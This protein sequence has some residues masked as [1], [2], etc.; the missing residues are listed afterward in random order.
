MGGPA[1]GELVSGE[2][3]TRADALGRVLPMLVPTGLAAL[4]AALALSLRRHWARPAVLLPVF[5]AAL[6]PALSGTG[7]MGDLVTGALMALPIVA[8]LVWYLY[9]VEGVKAYFAD[10]RDPGEPG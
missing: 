9:F 5:L 1:R 10:L 2:T 8:V 3:L 6:G 4:G 7:T